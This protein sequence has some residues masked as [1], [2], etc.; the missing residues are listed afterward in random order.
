[1]LDAMLEAVTE[2]QKRICQVAL[3]PVH[4]PSHELRRHISQTDACDDPRHPRHPRAMDG[5]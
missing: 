2:S 1:M 4:W 5:E 3:R